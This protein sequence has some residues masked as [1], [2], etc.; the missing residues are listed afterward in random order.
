M[1]THIHTTVSDGTDTPEQLLGKV[2]DAGIEFFSITDH[3]AVKGCNDIAGILTASD[4]KFVTGVEFGAEDDEGK[5]HILGYGYDP[6]TDSILE[7][8]KMA[9]DLRTMK[10]TTRIDGLKSRY[11]FTFPQ[12]DLDALFGLYNP[13]KPHIANLMVKYGYAMS[14]DEAIKEYLDAIKIPKSHIT[15]QEAIN[16]ILGSG[17][18]PVLA[19]PTYGSGDELIL[20]DE[21]DERIQKL[22][23]Y[24]LQGVEGY[25]SQYTAR[26]CDQVQSI[27]EK[28]D[29]YVSAGSDYHG[30]NKLV[31]LGDTGLDAAVQRPRGLIRFIEKACSLSAQIG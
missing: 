25:Y 21:L 6:N 28:Y 24:G 19:H 8:V 9:R 4:P 10:V 29:L 1:D 18:I 16:G 14:K 31:M 17:G 13:G 23:S 30:K 2:K 12:E 7:V 27:A 22:M 3:D 5:Y 20:G 15:P 11:G 26:M